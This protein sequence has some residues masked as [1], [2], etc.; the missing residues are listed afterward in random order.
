MDS[1]IRGHHVYKSIW[2]P[3]MGEVRVEIEQGNEEDR[4]AVVILKDG[5]AFSSAMS[6]AA[7]SERFISF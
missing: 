5:G 7:S 4:Y 6:L 3:F 2:I 1:V